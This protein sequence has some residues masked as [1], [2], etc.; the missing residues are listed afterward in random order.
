[1]NKNDQPSLAIIAKPLYVLAD[2]SFQP[3][4]D[5]EYGGFRKNT[6]NQTPG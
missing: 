3:R 5:V 1:M 2:C 6:W 4:C